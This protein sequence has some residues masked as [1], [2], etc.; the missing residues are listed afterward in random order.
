MN[1]CTVLRRAI[2]SGFGGF[3]ETGRAA[4]TRPPSPLLTRLLVPHPLKGPLCL[5]RTPPSRHHPATPFYFY[6]SSLFS[7]SPGTISAFGVLQRPSAHLSLR[8]L[9]P[10]TTVI[11]HSGV[12]GGLSPVRLSTLHRP[13]SGSH[14][15]FPVYSALSGPLLSSYLSLSGFESSPL[16]LSRRVFVYFDFLACAFSA[17]PLFLLRGRRRFV[18]HCGLC[19]SVASE[20]TR[21]SRF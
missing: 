21:L 10:L 1:G 11:L 6:F 19:T 8:R 15:H 14:F 9:V 17:G 20:L 4:P 3:F 16:S 12:L 2:G 18:P 5:V 7:P 13:L